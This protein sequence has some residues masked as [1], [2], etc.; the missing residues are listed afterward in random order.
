[1][2]RCRRLLNVLHRDGVARPCGVGLA[3]ALTRDRGLQPPPRYK[4]SCRCFQKRDELVVCGLP[5][6]QETGPLPS[7]LPERAPRKV[8]AEAT[9]SLPFVSRLV[10]VRL[11]GRLS[12]VGATAVVILFAKPTTL[13][14]SEAI[15]P[16]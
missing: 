2:T 13:G 16:S 9:L 6:I 11:P 10:I 3:S 5:V 7:L 8:V 12:G 15:S 14:V 4:L 1:M